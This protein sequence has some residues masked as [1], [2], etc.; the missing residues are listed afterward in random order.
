MV[1]HWR[2]DPWVMAVGRVGSAPSSRDLD[3]LT[4]D[5]GDVKD[6]SRCQ[7]HKCELR[8]PAAAIERFRSAID[9]SSPDRAANA[10]GMFR[11]TLASYAGSYLDHGNDALFE[12]A[13]NDDP[14]HIADG[15]R[16]IVTRSP[17]IGEAAPDLYAYLDQFPRERPA[18][19]EDFIYWMKEKFWITNV[20]SLNHATV[21]DRTT[22]A[23]RLILAVSK[24]LYA[25]HYYEA[26]VSLTA[27]VQGPEGES[28]LV[29]LTRA[30]AD[31]RRSGFNWMERL[32]L[33]RLVRNRI[34]SQVAYFKQRLEGV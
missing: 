29:S 27:Y 15:L 12:Y 13:N 2:Q 14:V 3:G 30:R 26:S 24:Q 6:L 22:T 16:R 23:G 28:Y 17:F 34:E 11:E 18:D 1:E 32:L 19:A 4:L 5:P 9:W 31:I 10:M 33:N 7:L 20:V 21:L 25:T 8:L